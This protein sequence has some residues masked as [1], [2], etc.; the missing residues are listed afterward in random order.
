MDARAKSEASSSIHSR[1]REVGDALPELGPPD[2]MRN[3]RHRVD[4][5]QYQAHVDADVLQPLPRQPTIGEAT[6]HPA[7]EPLN[8]RQKPFVDSLLPLGALN[9][10]SVLRRQDIRRVLPALQPPPED[11]VAHLQRLEEVEYAL[12]L[13]L[14]VCCEQLQL[15]YNTIH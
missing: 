9:V 10:Y 5:T 4:H 12:G 7:D 2:A 15:G 6:P 8:H 3:D 11:D 14:V 13:K 1:A